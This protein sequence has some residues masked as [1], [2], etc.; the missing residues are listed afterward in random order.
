MSLNDATADAERNAIVNALLDAGLWVVVIAP[1]TNG[2]WITYK[3]EVEGRKTPLTRVVAVMGALG[4]EVCTHGRD[5][6][7]ET[8]RAERRDAA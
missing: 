3:G 6:Q 5:G 2:W 7:G 4:Y 8:V 1:C